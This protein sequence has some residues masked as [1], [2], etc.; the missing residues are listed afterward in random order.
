M[1]LFFPEENQLCFE[2]NFQRGS[3]DPR[4]SP[5]YEPVVVRGSFRHTSSSAG[6]WHNSALIYNKIYIVID[7]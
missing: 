7:K 3:V 2:C 1:F 4:D 6:K 5:R